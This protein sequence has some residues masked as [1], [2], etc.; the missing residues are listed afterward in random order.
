VDLH[1]GDIFNIH[2]TY[3]GATLTMTI[4]DTVTYA[5]FSQSWPINIPGAIGGSMAH[6]GFTGASGGATAIQDILNWTFASPE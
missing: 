5:V 6:I 3:D 2:M 1:S 4:T